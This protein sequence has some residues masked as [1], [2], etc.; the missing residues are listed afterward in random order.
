MKI[1]K[2]GQLYIPYPLL[3]LKHDWC[4]HTCTSVKLNGP[5]RSYDSWI[6]ITCWQEYQYDMVSEQ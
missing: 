2:Q 5:S 3:G 1:L 4:R 6:C